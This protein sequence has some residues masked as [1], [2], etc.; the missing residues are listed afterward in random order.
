MSSEL[1]LSLS[2]FSLRRGVATPAVLARLAT[3]GL[4]C[5][6]CCAA[7]GS[8]S[9]VGCAPLSVESDRED[10]KECLKCGFGAP[11]WGGAWMVPTLG[12]RLVRV[13]VFARPRSWGLLVRTGV[14]WEVERSREG[15][16]VVGGAGAGR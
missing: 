8:F 15:K 14:R 5:C 3:A 4:G 7:L 1:S 6:A 2:F 13:V 9:L 10:R 16:A 12:G 11:V